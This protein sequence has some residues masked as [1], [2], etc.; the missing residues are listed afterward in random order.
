M[1]KW[2]E[3]KKVICAECDKEMILPL[4]SKR[5][6]CSWECYRKSRVGKKP[7][8]YGMHYSYVK[9][10][11][12]TCS[13]CDK[14]FE[15]IPSDKKQKYCSKECSRNA[16]PTLEEKI[17]HKKELDRKWN[18]T[19]KHKKA[20][21]EWSKKHPE[22]VRVAQQ[23]AYA[24]KTGKTKIKPCEVCGNK[25]DL[26]KH[27]PDYIKVLEIEWLCRRCHTQLHNLL[28]KNLLDKSPKVCI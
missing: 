25:K 23:T 12:K 20:C 22:R 2:G 6:R 27:H 21:I 8:N 5:K 19:E 15:V 3:R 7:G 9:R 4:S 24:Y 16:K 1:S 14:I 11:K 13:E 17:A 26:Q 18:K 28:R 10:I